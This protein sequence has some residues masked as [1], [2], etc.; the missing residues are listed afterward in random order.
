M[1]KIVIIGAGDQGLSALHILRLMKEGSDVAGFLDDRARGEAAGLKVLGPIEWAKANR[2]H[3]YVLA[4]ASPADRKAIVERLAEAELSYFSVVHPS[5]IIGPGVTL[6]RGVIL[7]AGVIAAHCARLDD[8]VHVNL[9]STVGHDC[10]LSRFVTVSPGVNIGGRVTLG[11]GVFV[12]MNACFSQGIAIGEWSKISMGSV[13][14]K[15]F[16]A[17]KVVAGNPAR[18]MGF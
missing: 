16:P 4:V 2:D 9:A 17:R 8:F 5:V 3:V 13:V 12:G 1:K 18:V 15:A 14:A 11:E 7:G 10:V 6:G